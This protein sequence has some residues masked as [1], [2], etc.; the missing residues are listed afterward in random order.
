MMWVGLVS[1]PNPLAFGSGNSRFLSSYMTESNSGK[2][3]GPE[4]L[5]TEKLTLKV[6][7]PLFGGFIHPSDFPKSG[8]DPV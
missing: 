6:K 4:F 8:R 2:L 1:F 7:I 5:L 3:F